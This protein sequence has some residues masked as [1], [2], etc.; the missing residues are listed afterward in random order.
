MLDTAK[1]KVKLT[2]SIPVYQN[3][4]ALTTRLSANRKEGE[5]PAAA[6]AG[7]QPFETAQAM[8]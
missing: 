8:R 3:E 2:F 4:R 1:P 6:P 5:E 7:P